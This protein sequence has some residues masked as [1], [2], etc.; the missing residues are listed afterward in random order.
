MEIPALLPYVLLVERSAEGRFRFRLAGTAV[1]EAYGMELTGRYVDE[2]FPPTRRVL[3][4]QHYAMVYEFARP[5]RAINRYT[6]S[7]GVEHVASRLILPLAGAGE[8]ASPVQ[9]LLIGQ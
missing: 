2:V 1:V 8:S 3:A 6:N 7:R 5:I 4:E 9:F